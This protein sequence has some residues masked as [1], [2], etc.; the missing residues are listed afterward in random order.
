MDARRALRDMMEQDRCLAEIVDAPLAVEKYLAFVSDPSAGA[1]SSFMGVTRDN[2]DG[3]AV[4][5]LEYEAYGPMALKK[6]HVGVDGL[7]LDDMRTKFCRRSA[8]RCVTDGKC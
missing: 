5:K 3:K 1:V 2:F 6:M 8:L 4:H 7:S